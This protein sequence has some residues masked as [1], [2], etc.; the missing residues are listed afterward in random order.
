MLVEAMSV[1]VEAVEVSIEAMGV[2]EEAVML[3]KKQLVHE[4]A[5]IMS[6]RQ[7]PILPNICSHNMRKT[8][9]KNIVKSVLKS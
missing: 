2:S 4:E 6:I 9:C 3:M 7:D 1:L 5:L 8:I